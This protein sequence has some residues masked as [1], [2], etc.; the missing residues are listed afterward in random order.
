[1]NTILRLALGLLVL[2][3]I[4][5][6]GCTDS[7][8]PTDDPRHVKDGGAPVVDTKKTLFDKNIFFETKG[9]RH[10]VILSAHVVKREGGPL[11]LFLCRA[12]S[13]EQ[14]SSKEHE[15]IL[16]ADVE[17]LQV[18]MALRR[19]G[20]KAGG[21]VRFEPKFRPPSGTTIKVTVLYQKKGLEITAPA[22]SWVRDLKTQK[23]MT[24]DWVFAGSQL[25]PN[26]LDD[27]APPTYYANQDG[28]GTLLTL[29]NFES[30]VMDLPINSLKGWNN[31]EYEPFTERIPP[32]GTAVSV[33]LEP[34]LRVRIA[35]QGHLSQGRGGRAGGNASRI[36]LHF[37]V[38]RASG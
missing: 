33:I 18:H 26:P 30:A 37:A 1:M 29:V 5:A 21:T 25:F 22:Q 13:K 12:V 31:Q 14:P 8:G 17:P 28:E 7:S 6:A 2:A 35:V 3:A 27:K 20:A 4:A 23:E 10:R 16:S 36:F 19:A 9:D 11:E 34:V 15:S 38:R 24:Y 32:E